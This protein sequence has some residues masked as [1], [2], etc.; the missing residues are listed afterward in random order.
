MIR[1]RLNDELARTD[2]TWG[3]RNNLGGMNGVTI[4]FT[5]TKHAVNLLSN[6]YVIS[7]F[8]KYLLIFYMT[9]AKSFACGA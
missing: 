1:A 6:Q 7:D 9:V 3:Q 8:G 5:R 4:V 2:W